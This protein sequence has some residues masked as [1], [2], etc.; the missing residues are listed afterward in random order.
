VSASPKNKLGWAII[1]FAILFISPLKA[2]ANKEPVMRVLIDNVKNARFRGDGLESIL[3][4]GISSK[5][6]RI[7]SIN[8]IYR[9]SNV[10]YSINNDF[11]VLFELPNNFNLIIK[12]H[13]KR[14]I[15]YKNRRYAGELRVALNDQ[16]L[17][18]INYLKLEKY[19]NSV[20]G[21]EMP[22]E[23]PLAA[24]QAQ[25]IAARTYALKLLGKN[26]LFD[27]HSTQASQ[28]YLGLE[29]ETPKTNKA[30]K[31]TKS[32][33]LFYQNKLIN[34]VFHSSSGG[35]TENS[36]EVWRYQLPYLRSVIDYDQNSTK[37]RW[38]NKFTSSEL[39]KIF[40][41]LGGLNSIKITKKSKSQR[42]LKIRLNGPNGNKNISGKSL[43]EKLKLLSTKFEVDLQFNKINP[44]EE[45]KVRNYYSDKSN[46]NSDNNIR[47]DLAPQPLPLIPA[48]YLLLVKGYGAGHGVG[49]SQWGAKAMAERGSSFSQILK[50]YYTGVQIMT[51]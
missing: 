10:K 11:N 24:L 27:V 36:G 9:N 2:T 31:S 13:D 18:I 12:N 33:A 6:R 14:G 25:A 44:N 38:S 26:K 7:K 15:W 46:L 48:E 35:K 8:L 40:P 1:F 49:M 23:F 37:F 19:L 21:S 20:V 22:K 51:Y 39:E 17:Q 5:H 43:R 32:L 29:S 3:I 41:D 4:T 45:F 42:V 34:A 28:V 47:N 50:H 30:V 16:K